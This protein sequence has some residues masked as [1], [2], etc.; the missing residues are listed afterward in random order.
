MDESYRI[1]WTTED[2]D[3]L[4]EEFS[5]NC[6]SPIDA[7]R[8]Y[9]TLRMQKNKKLENAQVFPGDEEPLVNIARSGTEDL[10]PMA[11]TL[12]R[13]PDP[14]KDSFGS[15]DSSFINKVTWSNFDSS[16]GVHFKRGGYIIYTSDY[17]T[18]GAFKNWV[19]M[20]NSTG[21]FYNS[22]IKGL[23]VIKRK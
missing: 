22:N 17:E 1:E 18:F 2:G 23:P 4:H 20:G 19:A 6:D 13:Q 3:L 8:A 12:G 15:P 21:A 11:E 9:V 7:V 5:V 14:K 16:I 10:H